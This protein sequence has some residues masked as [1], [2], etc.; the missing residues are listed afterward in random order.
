MELLNY[1]S[2]SERFIT[3]FASNTHS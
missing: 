2:I 1:I 3:V